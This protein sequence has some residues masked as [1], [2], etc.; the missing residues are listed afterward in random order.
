[1]S[2]V[3]RVI[4]KK[5]LMMGLPTDWAVFSVVLVGLVYF[6]LWYGLRIPKILEGWHVYT[7]C[8]VIGMILW[9]FGYIKAGVDAEFF[10]VH[11]AKFKIPA[12][13]I[14]HRF[15]RYKNK[16]EIEP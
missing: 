16:I 7:I 10:S 1:M 12:V 5:R 13:S 14:V 11:I 6:P 15:N 8:G 3:H 2:K 9:G 4:T